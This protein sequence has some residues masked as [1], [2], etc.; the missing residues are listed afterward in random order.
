[1]DDHSTTLGFIEQSNLLPG[2]NLTY[3]DTEKYHFK[4]MVGFVFLLFASGSLHH[5]AFCFDVAQTN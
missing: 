2:C 5:R 4:V 3:Q 1:M